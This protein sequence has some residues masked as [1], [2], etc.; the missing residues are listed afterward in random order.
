MSI[1]TSSVVVLIFS[2]DYL[3]HSQVK[4]NKPMKTWLVSDPDFY[5][6]TIGSND[7]LSSPPAP[8]EFK[9]KSGEV[10]FSLEE[11]KGKWDRV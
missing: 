1:A 10:F 11:L 9:H 5:K 4:L 8:V 7:T 6:Q 3:A 2:A